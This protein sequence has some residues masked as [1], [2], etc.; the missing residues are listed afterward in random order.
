MN[1]IKAIGTVM[2][3]FVLVSCGITAG[4]PVSGIVREAGTD[5]RIPGA[6][7][8]ATWNYY[9]WGS[10]C[11]HVQTAITNKYGQYYFPVQWG[12]MW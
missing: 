5:K 3:G 12:G 10:H 9:L 8:A 6:V 2:L 11:F 7:V 4:Y 1:F